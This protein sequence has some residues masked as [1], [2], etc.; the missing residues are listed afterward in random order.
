MCHDIQLFLLD[1]KKQLDI[2][3]CYRDIPAPSIEDPALI[4]LH[5]QGHGY[6]LILK[7]LYTTLSGMYAIVE[8]VYQSTNMRAA[9]STRPSGPHLDDIS[10][11]S[12]CQSHLWKV[13]AFGKPCSTFLDPV[14]LRTRSMNIQKIHHRGADDDNHAEDV[15]KNP[16]LDTWVIGKEPLILFKGNYQSINLLEEISVQISSRLEEKH[17]TIFMISEPCSREYFL[18]KDEM[19]LLRQLAIQALRKISVPWNAPFLTRIS[20]RFQKALS[21]QD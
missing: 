11:P 7:E 21:Y 5:A 4:T 8:L 6:L 15:W 10:L 19:E 12:G 18:D 2:A 3:S 20:T 14:G 16:C 9:Y 1:I 17:S 13:P